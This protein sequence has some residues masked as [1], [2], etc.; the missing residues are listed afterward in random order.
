MDRRGG[1]VAARCRRAR[2]GVGSAA[3]RLPAARVAA[4]AGTARVSDDRARPGQGARR[5]RRRLVLAGIR[6]NQGT[7]DAGPA[8]QPQVP[9]P[10]PPGPTPRAGSTGRARPAGG[11]PAV[12]LRR[13]GGRRLQ[14][15]LAAG[16]LMAK[17][18]PR[19]IRV[20]DT[21][22]AATDG[23][24]ADRWG[25]WVSA[26]VPL[27]DP[28]TGQPLAVLGMDID[29]SRWAWDVAAGVRAA[30]RID[31]GAAARRGLGASRREVAHARAIKPI[32]HRL[33][34]R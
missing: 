13:F 17:P 26:L 21:R 11:R 33:G 19:Y 8:G 7:A 27:T 34:S 29:G 31:A 5:I 24:V 3:R 22:T 10:V 25:T 9:V 16:D 1:R 4:G 20:F 14:G 32:Q 30:G 6:A 15:L 28:D 18:R 23:P 2:H 12:H